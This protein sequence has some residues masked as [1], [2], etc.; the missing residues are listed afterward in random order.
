MIRRIS[1]FGGPNCSKSTLAMR[2]TAD[3][4]SRRVEAE[5]CQEYV[6]AWSFIGTAIRGYDQFYILSKQMH[7]ED[8]ILRASESIVITDSP[9]LLGVCYAK[10]NGLKIWPHLMKVGLMFEED[11]PSL[12]IFVERKGLAYSQIGRY[13]N[14]EQAKA[15]D[16][17][18][19]ETMADQGINLECFGYDDYD[20]ILER[21]LK[22]LGVG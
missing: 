15:M 14:Y 19:K 1:F 21:A 5:H 9:V 4:K 11:Y 6:K 22:A 12:N 3:L 7:R 2:L 8:I 18:I 20:R 13:E 10:R 17:V 16:E